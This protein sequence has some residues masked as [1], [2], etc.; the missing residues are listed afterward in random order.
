MLKSVLKSGQD[1]DLRFGKLLK[2]LAGTTGLEPATS[3][4]TDKKHAF[5]KFLPFNRS[6]ENIELKSGKRVCPAVVGCGQMYVGSLHFPLQ[7][8]DLYLGAA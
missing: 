3:C 6:T 2:T 5:S 4:V 8:R 7:S 1:G